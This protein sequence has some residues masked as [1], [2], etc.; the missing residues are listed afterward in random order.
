MKLYE[1]KQWP[2]IWEIA[3]T[4]AKKQ[5]GNKYSEQDPL[6]SAFIWTS[7]N[8]CKL[9]SLLNDNNVSK[10]KSIYPEIFSNTKIYEL[11]T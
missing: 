6:V 11:W 9:F 8:Y 10:A 2:K 1:L 3:E 4:A 5:S 7:T